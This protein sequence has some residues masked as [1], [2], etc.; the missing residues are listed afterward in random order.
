MR[1]TRVAIHGKRKIPS[2]IIALLTPE[3]QALSRRAGEE[4]RKKDLPALHV[5]RRP[6]LEYLANGFRDNSSKF[7]TTDTMR[8]GRKRLDVFVKA[9]T[10]S[11]SSLALPARLNQCCPTGTRRARSRPPVPR[12][13]ARAGPQLRKH[14]ARAAR[15]AG[16]RGTLNHSAL[17]GR[18]G[19]ADG[20]AKYNVSRQMLLIHYII[21]T[22]VVSTRSAR[23][24]R[25]PLPVPTK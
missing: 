13:K 21:I 23:R 2:R 7:H 24:A 3:R 19:R 20:S 18:A 22:R 10:N 6:H 5:L 15:G 25:R 11:S 12:G 16:V 17:D 1:V 9:K 4:P 8:N 14:C